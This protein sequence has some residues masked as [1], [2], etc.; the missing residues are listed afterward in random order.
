MS[1]TSSELLLEIWDLVRENITPNKRE[2][3]AEAL[4]NIFENYGES[5]ADMDDLEGSDKYIDKALNTLYP[6]DEDDE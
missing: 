3:V 1:Q 5:P 4:L 6:E 2:A